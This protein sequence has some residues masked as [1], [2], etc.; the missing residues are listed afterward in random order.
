[1]KSIFASLIASSA[2]IVSIQAADVSAKITNVHL[3]CNACVTGAQKAV[4][5]VQGVSAAVDKDAGIVSLTGQ[6]AAALQKAA[7]ALVAAGYFGKSSDANLKIKDS[8]NAKG[9]KVQSL[10][11]TGVHLCCNK[12][13]TSLDEA[14]KSVPGVKSHTAE[15]GAKSFEVKGDFNDKDVFSALHKAGLAG[16]AGQ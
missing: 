4:G 9:Q 10:Q 6:D 3:C 12:C 16:Q 13:V 5:K 8:T 7:D 11:V 15:K 2:L 1:M 14:V